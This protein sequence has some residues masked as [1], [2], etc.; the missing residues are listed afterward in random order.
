MDVVGAPELH[1]PPERG[2]GPEPLGHDR[3]DGMP[4]RPSQ[5]I[6]AIANHPN[7]KAA[8]R[9]VI[10]PTTTA[11]SQVASGGLLWRMAEAAA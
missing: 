2:E 6:A 8:G 11:T 4:A 1:R 9:N 7:R 3:R 10:V 5:R